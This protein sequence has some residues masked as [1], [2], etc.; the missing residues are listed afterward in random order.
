MTTFEFF[1]ESATADV[2]L[3]VQQPGLSGSVELIKRLNVLIDCGAGRRVGSRYG[4][5]AADLTVDDVRQLF[6]GIG[7][8]HVGR[9][10]KP[11][12]GPLLATDTALVAVPQTRCSPPAL[13]SGA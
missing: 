7:T 9:P 8:V 6:K 4:E 5:L 3:E 10:T 1:V 13:V 11:D 2:R 12:P